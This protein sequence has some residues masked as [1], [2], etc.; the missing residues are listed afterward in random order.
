MTADQK[1]KSGVYVDMPRGFSKPGKVLKLRK[2]LYGLK[3]SPRCFFLH[4]KDV[5]KE[6]GL[7]QQVDVDPCLFM[8]D[9]VICIIYVDDTLLFAKTMEDISDVLAIISKKIKLE[10]EDDVAGFLG[11]HI[12]RDDKKGE[13]LLTQTGLID[14]IIEALQCDQLPPKETPA[15]D[16]LGKDQDGDPPNCAFNYASVIGMLWYVEAHSRP[17]IGFAVSQCAQFAF[18]PKQSH[19][20]A[21]IRIGQYLLGTRD[22]GL[23]MKPTPVDDLHMEVYVD[24][25]FMGLYGK[26]LRSDPTNVKSRTGFVILL[27]RCPIIWSSKLQESIALSTMMAEYYALSTAM[28]EV[29]PLRGLVHSVAKGVGLGKCLTTFHTT[30]HEDN[31]GALALA[32]LDPGQHTPRSKFY[33]VKVHWF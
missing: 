17:D 26:E 21:M 11:V 18:S 25:D 1:A 29:I 20:L 31:S 28:R 33:D 24:S 27:N 19:E 22:K 4:L 7:K 15:M 6:A 12:A 3:N 14:R 32:N 2:A 9:K 8:S 13:I 5:L 10:E 30:V 16:V 23:I